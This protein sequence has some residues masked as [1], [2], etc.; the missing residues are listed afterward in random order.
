M[1]LQI[2]GALPK[3]DLAGSAEFLRRSTSL[4]KVFSDHAGKP[5]ASVPGLRSLAA[6][7]AKAGDLEQMAILL[8]P[9]HGR[10]DL[11][12]EYFALAMTHKGVPQM[13]KIFLDSGADIHFDREAALRSAVAANCFSAFAPL[14]RAGADIHV[15]NE[16]PLRIAI[17]V[18]DSSTA[19][20]LIKRGADPKVAAENE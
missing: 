13:V 17:K 8:D 9:K 3:R 11:A 20:F 12:N 19:R 4:L 1:L 16:E 15:N 2:G 6:A 18:G 5:E 7:V 10:K 14:I